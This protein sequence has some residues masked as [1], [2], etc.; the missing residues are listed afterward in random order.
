MKKDSKTWGERIVD[1]LMDKLADKISA[2]EMIKA[3][4]AAEAAETQR[5]RTQVVQYQQELEEILSSPRARA[6]DALASAVWA[7]FSSGSCSSMSVMTCSAFTR[8]AP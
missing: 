6:A 4:A 1:N 5:L 8:S 2:T 7:A 3:N